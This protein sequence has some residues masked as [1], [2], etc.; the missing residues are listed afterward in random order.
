MLA[1][2]KHTKVGTLVI[3]FNFLKKLRSNPTLNNCKWY[4]KEK[5]I[6]IENPNHYNVI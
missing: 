3:M 6:L 4:I 5:N 1:I 2:S